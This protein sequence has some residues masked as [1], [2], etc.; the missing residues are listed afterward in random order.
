MST[1]S[2]CDVSLIRFGYADKALTRQVE[3]LLKTRSFLDTNV[4]DHLVPSARRE[5]AN[6]VLMLANGGDCSPRALGQNF[7][8]A[9][10]WFD[11][12]VNTALS[13]LGK[14]PCQ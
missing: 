11:G 1:M 12:A 10:K 13:R 14:A 4:F 8:M 6:V 9:L 7:K 2:L 5:R 3:A